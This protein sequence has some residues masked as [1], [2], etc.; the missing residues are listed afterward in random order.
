M[1][2][3]KKFFNPLL[4]SRVVLGHSH[5]FL[6]LQRE[7]QA[8][9]SNF[10]ESPLSFGLDVFLGVDDPAGRPH[11]LEGCYEENTEEYSYNWF[12]CRYNN[13]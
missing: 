5:A 12:V 13:F 3:I 8:L 11:N 10:D 7:I 4:F 1:Y 9:F 2:A 6:W